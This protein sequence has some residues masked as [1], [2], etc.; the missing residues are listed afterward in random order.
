[1]CRISPNQLRLESRNSDLSRVYRSILRIHRSL[2]LI[3]RWNFWRWPGLPSPNWPCSAIREGPLHD[4]ADV[5][6]ERG[7]VR[8]PPERGLRQGAARGLQHPPALEGREQAGCELRV[9]G[10]ECEHRL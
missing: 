1:M 2:L 9:L 7:G 5:T 8:D 6:G 3:H 4:V 10:I